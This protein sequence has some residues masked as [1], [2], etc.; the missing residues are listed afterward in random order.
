MKAPM[1]RRVVSQQADR[2]FQGEGLAVAHPMAQQMGLQRAVHDL[3]NVGAGVG[4][5]HHRTRVPDHLEHVVLV[6]VGDGL[7][8]ELPQIRLEGELD[9]QIDRVHRPGAGDVGDP[10][11]FAQHRIQDVEVLPAGR[12]RFDA[13]DAVLGRLAVGDLDQLCAQ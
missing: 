9:H 7:E 13:D 2:L 4:E 10:F 5:S 11:V 6:F 12:P 1:G 3:R 8:K